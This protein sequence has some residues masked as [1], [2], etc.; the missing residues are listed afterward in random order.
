MPDG[1]EELLQEPFYSLISRA[2]E[3]TIESAT[4]VFYL[5]AWL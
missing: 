3:K 2:L 4:I 5:V 1:Y